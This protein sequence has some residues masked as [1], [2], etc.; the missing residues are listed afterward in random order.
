MTDHVILSEQ[1]SLEL[2]PPELLLRGE[3]KLENVNDNAYDFKG[4]LS[5]LIPSK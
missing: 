4:A 3:T 1:S 5:A 2:K